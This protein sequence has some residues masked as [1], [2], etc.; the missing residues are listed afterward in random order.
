MRIYFDNTLVDDFMTYAM[1]RKAGE[2]KRFRIMKYFTF[3]DVKALVE[4][5]SDGKKIYCNDK[6]QT[7]FDGEERAG[8]PSIIWLP[9]GRRIDNY[10][11]IIAYEKDEFKTNREGFI[12]ENIFHWLWCDIERILRCNH[13]NIIDDYDKRLLNRARKQFCDG[14]VTII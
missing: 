8:M 11:D 10:A 2:E 9:D 14:G 7:F 5:Y 12:E 4:Y 3:E 1:E 6:G 13:Q